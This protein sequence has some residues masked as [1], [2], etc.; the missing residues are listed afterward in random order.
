MKKIKLPTG[1]RDEFGLMAEQKDILSHQI[2]AA[3]RHKGYTRIITPLL[4]QEELF[5]NYELKDQMYKFIDADGRALVL[6]PDLTLPVARFLENN[7]VV[8]PQKFYYL[9]EEL[10]IGRQFMG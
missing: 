1:L 3:F 7:N 4:E 9:G 8:L 6:R 10:S 5:Q 2:L